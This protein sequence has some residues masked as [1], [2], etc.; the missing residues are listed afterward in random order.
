MKKHF[1]NTIVGSWTKVFISAAILQLSNYLS[2]GKAIV[3]NKELL[4]DLFM[5]GLIATLPV[6][7]NYLNPNDPR[8]GRNK[9]PQE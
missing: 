3:I 9:T 2:H 6:I 5:A 1:S 8:Y 4:L 7:Y